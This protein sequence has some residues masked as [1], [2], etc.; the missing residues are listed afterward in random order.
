MKTGEIETLLGSAQTLKKHYEVSQ[1]EMAEQRESFEKEKLQLQQ[2]QQQATIEAQYK[3]IQELRGNPASTGYAQPPAAMA[4]QQ[5]Q[6]QQQPQHFNN[7]QPGGPIRIGGISPPRPVHSG[8][9]GGGGGGN[10]SN[11]NQYDIMASLQRRVA[12]NMYR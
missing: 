5:Q 3:I 7:A 10:P 11:P 2:S 12:E 1:K 8:Q 6:Q 4:P 9:G